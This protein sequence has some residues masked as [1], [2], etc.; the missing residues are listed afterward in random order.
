MRRI[1]CALVVLLV[2]G[3]A[4]D[5]AAAGFDAAKLAAVKKAASDFQA[6]AKGSATSG[7]PPRETDPKAKALLAAVFDTSVLDTPQPLPASE[8][9]NLSEWLLHVVQVGGV[10]ILA[11]TGQ[12][13]FSQLSKLDQAAQQKL[14]RQIIQNTIAFAPEM[15]WYFDGQLGVT[16]TLIWS[17]SA[18]MAAH[19][20]NAK[21]AQA[22]RGIAQMRA[23]LVNTL[24][25]VLTTL[26]TNGLSDE[27]RRARLPAMAALAPKAAA[28]L[29]PDQRRSVHDTA[30]QVAGQMGDPEVKKGLTA[31]AQAVGG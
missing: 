25:G 14:Q 17:V 22:Q 23:G 30:L 27:W 6:L 2:G 1:A 16:R 21:S 5:A 13:D 18:D 28:F 12:A 10:Y 11:G 7:K 8:V 29:L 24:T 15:G 3:L 19:P 20:D 26:P 31:F 4:A 9:G